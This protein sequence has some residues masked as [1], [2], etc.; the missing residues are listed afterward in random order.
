MS[1]SSLVS[2]P[3]NTS[4]RR[5][6]ELVCDESTAPPPPSVPT[7]EPPAPSPFMPPNQPAEEQLE[8]ALSRGTDPFLEAVGDP[9]LTP[10]EPNAELASD[11]TFHAATSAPPSPP[12]PLSPPSPPS[13]VSI[14]SV[15]SGAA[16]K[17]N[18][19]GVDSGY[20]ISHVECLGGS[21]WTRAFGLDGN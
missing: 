19:N 13:S 12:E 11:A 8:E 15:T 18:R 1:M 10:D 6:R 21:D 9:F 17:S 20:R 7:V 5:G 3:R 4:E 16:R 2:R 14:A